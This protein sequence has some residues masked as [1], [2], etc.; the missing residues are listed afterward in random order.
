M[1]LFFQDAEPEKNGL[2]AH[3]AKDRGETKNR[4]KTIFSPFA[5]LMFQQ[6]RIGGNGEAV[7]IM[8]ESVLIRNESPINAKG[9]KVDQ[10]TLRKVDVCSKSLI[11]SI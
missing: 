10:S 7:V 5:G 1:A 11:F 3:H 8:L 2:P 4:S 9:S 6:R